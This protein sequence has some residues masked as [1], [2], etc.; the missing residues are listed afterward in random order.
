MNAPLGLGI[1]GAARIARSFIAG[2]A[3]SM[4]VRVVAVASRDAARAAQFAADTGVG[5]WHGSYESLIA[6][7][8]VEAVYVPLPNGLHAEWAIRALHAGKHVLCEKPLAATHAEAA[9]MFA[10]AR[11]AGRVLV[12]GFPYLAQPHALKLRQ[13]VA[14]GEIGRL[15]T[16]QAAFGFTLADRANIRFD[17]ALGGGAL[18]DVGVYPI[19]LVRVLVGARP[20]RVHAVARWDIGGVDETLVATLEHADGPLAQ[21][22]CGFA[23]SA[24]RYAVIAGTA[25]V[26]RTTYPNTPPAGQPGIVEIKRGVA[27]DLDYESIQ[28]PALNGFRAEAE[29]FERLLRAGPDHWSGATAAESLDIMA[30]LDAVLA[31]ARSGRP[32]EL[33]PA[34]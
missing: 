18:L 13:L 5:R 9:A 19:S 12:E 14:A 2:V 8:D 27:A 17:A 32:V 10:A 6:D 29:S 1:L 28:V 4:S 33:A 22:S 3:P 7:P 25:G 23:A 21:I 34:R 31:S 20:W 16:I 26:L 11:R 24:H 30:T 15:Q